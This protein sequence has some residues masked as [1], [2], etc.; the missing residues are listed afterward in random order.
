MT[1]EVNV[2]VGGVVS[3]IKLADMDVVVAIEN[4]QGLFCLHVPPCQPINLLP[5]VGTAVRVIEEPA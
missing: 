2:T 3:G 4:V 5:T 1:G